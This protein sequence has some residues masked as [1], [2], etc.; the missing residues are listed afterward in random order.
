MTDASI[1]D[2]W[3]LALLAVW[4]LAFL[5]PVLARGWLWLGLLGLFALLPTA[6]LLLLSLTQSDDMAQGFGVLFAVTSALPALA[7]AA[8]RALS[9]AARSIG[10]PRPWSLWIEGFAALVTLAAYLLLF[11]IPL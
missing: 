5:L 7:G 10:H 6:L 2:L 3:P 8:A 1:T 4:L 9:L 11:G